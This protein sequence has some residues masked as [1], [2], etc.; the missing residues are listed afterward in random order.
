MW[1]E[2]YAHKQVAHDGRHAKGNEEAH[3][4]AR[5]RDNNQGLPQQ[6]IVH[7]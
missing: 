5:C 1:P 2:R 7:V 3:R 6:D 4:Q